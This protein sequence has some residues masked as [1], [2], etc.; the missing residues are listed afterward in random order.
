MRLRSSRGFCELPEG[1]AG[2]GV[3]EAGSCLTASFAGP[4]IF[5]V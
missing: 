3:L 2:C 1:A 5:S 4:P